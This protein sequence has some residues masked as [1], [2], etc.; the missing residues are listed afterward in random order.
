MEEIQK[1]KFYSVIADELCDVSNTEQLSISFRY[2]LD[3]NVKEV[4]ADFVEVERITGKQ[5]A[6]AIIQSLTT[7]GLSLHH[8]RGQ[9]YDGASN[10]A[11]ARSGCNAI[12]REKA[13]L[14]V[15]HHCAAHRLNLAIVSACK[16]AAFR[17]TES[18][19]G[20]I[21]RFFQFSAK[22]QRLLDKAIDSE[23]PAT[24][25]KKL[26]DTCKTRWIQ[27]IDSY[28]VF[29][30]LLPAVHITLQAMIAPA[31]F[32]NLGT[33]WNWDAE[34]VMKAT[35]FMY[36]LESSSFLIC[37]QILLECLTR[38]RSL[39][40]KLQMRAV[41]VLY[42]YKQVNK[43]LES[44]KSMRENAPAKFSIIFRETTQLAKSLHGED[45]ELRQPRLN[46]RQVH[47]DNVQAGSVEEY[48]RITLYNEFLSHIISE[49]EERFVN[50]PT[51]SIGLLQLLPNECNST[52]D[53]QTGLPPQLAEAA[54]FYDDDL[55][56][57][58]ML[59]MEYRRWVSKWKEPSCAIPAKL[60]DV[61]K[62]CDVM[63]FPNIH[64]L[65]QLALTLPI[66]SCECERSFSQLKLIKTSR[67]STTSAIRL[68]GLSLMKINR[69][70]CEKMYSS[71][72]ELK[73]L[74]LSFSQKYTR[75]IKLPF[76]L[77]DY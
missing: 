75:R 26:K 57:V 59:P 72:R 21:A 52:D 28:V 24:H 47:R 58:V 77:A 43:D 1:A 15:Y 16:I 64:V 49:L 33:E 73:Q 30:E 55:P 37:F 8:M 71:S 27:H 60:V 2:V 39:T 12:I 4:F 6:D 45:F 66:T 40:L 62:A 10:M 3:G 70:R 46:A 48:F 34:T 36:Q 69:A 35:G 11:G 13:P 51:H 50:T 44:L 63:S 54:K 65:L 9:C 74:V 19:I 7:W 25:S 23:C 29:L 38:M 17:N 53:D 41:D 68:S 67:R 61:F 5:L 20:E 22:R 76:M 18:Y 56:H 14:A 31:N 32:Q 42:A